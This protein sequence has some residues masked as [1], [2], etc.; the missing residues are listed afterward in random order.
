MEEIPNKQKRYS[1]WL[2]R[3]PTDL[4]CQFKARCAA[5]GKSMVET[6]ISLIRKYVMEK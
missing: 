2:V 1:L 3:I 6:I 5:R 4:K